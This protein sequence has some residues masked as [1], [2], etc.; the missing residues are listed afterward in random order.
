[1]K[2]L[3]L[4]ATGTI[5]R[6]TVGALQAA[7]HMVCCL[8]RPGTPEEGLSGVELV[9]GEATN[10]E[11]FRALIRPGRFEAI[12]SCLASRTG[13]PEDAR[14]IDRDAHLSV[15]AAAEAAGVARFIQLSAICVQK[16]ELTFQFA[17]L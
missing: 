4:G 11:T 1:M 13:A 8:V 6:A 3:L 10:P 16:P 17:K 14:A 9:R 7:G 12:V 15:L 2:V 5:G